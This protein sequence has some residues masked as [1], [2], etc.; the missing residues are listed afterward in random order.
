MTRKH[1]SSEH[2]NFASA[3]PEM[4][5]AQLVRL[6]ELGLA[7][8]Q[9]KVVPSGTAILVR[10][11]K[12]LLEASRRDNGLWNRVGIVTSESTKAKT[13]V[14]YVLADGE[15]HLLALTAAEP[16]IRELLADAR[17][18]GHLLV[19]WVTSVGD[20]RLS[21]VQFDES[22]AGMLKGT[23]HEITSDFLSPMYDLVRAVQYAFS[24][25]KLRQ[26]GI[27][28]GTVRRQVVHYLATP[29]MLDQ[30]NRLAGQWH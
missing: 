10:A 6:E 24:S 1:E 28:P 11:T 26:V 8:P 5:V 2:G 21:L 12:H 13:A 7:M 27:D 17:K 30:V 23:E 3:M 19:L 29:S 9:G 20:R 18:S 15:L 22:L 25:D 4:H 16:E 14:I